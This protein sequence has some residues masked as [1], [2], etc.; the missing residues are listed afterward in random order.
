MSELNTL[1]SKPL[2]DKDIAVMF[3][4]YSGVIVRTAGGTFVIDPANLLA[5]ADIAALKKNGLKAVLYTHGHGDHLDVATAKALVRETGAVI[6]A[7]PAVA[8]TLKAA[9]GIPADKL[10]T[11]V[12]GKDV[13]AGGLT[14][15]GFVGKHVGPIMLYRVQLGSLRFFHGG[16]S[17][18]VPIHD[19]AADLAFLPTGNPS[20]T[21]SPDS[22][23]K[24]AKDV[25]PK[26]A[27]LMHG[28]EAQHAAFK[29]LAESFLPDMTVEV[30]EP[31]KVRVL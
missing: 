28:A 7:E 12:A 17:A 24:M 15:R 10:I 29:K 22:A 20:P 27:L 16:D 23:F 9:G 30:M 14:V 4:S 11:A 1:F 18:Y 3:L 26:V 5:D 6:V 13:Q 21:A 8:A 2:K 19:G 25:K 31:F